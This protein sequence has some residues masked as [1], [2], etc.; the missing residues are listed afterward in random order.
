[1]ITVGPS[2][3]TRTS[4]EAATEGQSCEIVASCQGKKGGKDLPAAVNDP[5]TAQIVGRNLHLDAVARN[6][7]DEILAHA[8]GDMGNDLVAVVQFD[9][10]L[11]VGQRFF[12]AALHFNGFFFRHKTLSLRGMNRCK[13]VQSDQ[14]FVILYAVP[15]KSEPLAD[16]RV[17]HVR[18]RLVRFPG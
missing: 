12:D 1:M 7:A 5:A 2:L 6:D 15:R 11:R 9:A 3:V 13:C 4:W 18:K 8:A 16:L 10:K 14:L 17:A